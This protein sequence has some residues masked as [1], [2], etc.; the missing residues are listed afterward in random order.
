MSAAPK[1]TAKVIESNENTKG[2]TLLVCSKSSVKTNNI[3][4]MFI[5]HDHFSISPKYICNLFFT[6][7]LQCILERWV[8]SNLVLKILKHATGLAICHFTLPLCPHIIL[9]IT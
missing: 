2:T 5:V 8:F 9:V 3:T 4:K 7:H 1:T 6:I